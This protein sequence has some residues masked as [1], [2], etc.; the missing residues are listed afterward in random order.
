MLHLTLQTFTQLIEN[1]L[2]HKTMKNKNK[3]TS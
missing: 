1:H 2:I 3:L